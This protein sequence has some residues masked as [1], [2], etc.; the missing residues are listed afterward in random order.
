MPISGIEPSS[1]ITEPS[2]Q[3]NSD[4]FPINV[5]IK[6]KCDAKLMKKKNK[7]KPKKMVQWAHKI[8]IWISFKYKTNVNVEKTLYE[9]MEVDRITC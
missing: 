6:S 9:L 5:L 8:T 1:V 7:L 4:P 2:S 3:N